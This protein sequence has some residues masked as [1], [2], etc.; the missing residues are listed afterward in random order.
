MFTEREPNKSTGPSADETTSEKY[1]LPAI[2]VSIL[3][4][5]VKSYFSASSISPT[6]LSH[7]SPA[8]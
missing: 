3:P 6:S 7:L 5:Y 4:P 2:K 1:D 8:L